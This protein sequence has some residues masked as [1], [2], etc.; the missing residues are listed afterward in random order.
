[1]SRDHLK[2][3]ATPMKKTYLAVYYVFIGVTRQ[4][5]VFF[6]DINKNESE[7]FVQTRY[8]HVLVLPTVNLYMFLPRVVFFTDI[9][10]VSIDVINNR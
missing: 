8:L 4:D 7:R 5:F 2:F 6:P 3:I 10:L 9:H 1:M